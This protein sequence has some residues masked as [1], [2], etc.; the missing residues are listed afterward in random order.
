MGSA[1]IPATGLKV[2]E[3]RY[4]TNLNGGKTDENTIPTAGKT[5]ANIRTP[6]NPLRDIR[7]RDSRAPGERNATDDRVRA[8]RRI[9]P[10]GI[11]P[12]NL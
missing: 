1:A 6:A 2:R 7:L 3:P 9:P 12:P 4:H 11:G 8:G 10:G 5:P